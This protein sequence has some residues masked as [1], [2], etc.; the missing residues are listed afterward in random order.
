MIFLSFKNQPLFYHE[1]PFILLF[2]LSTFTTFSQTQ[3]IDS[4]PKDITVLNKGWKFHACD[5]VEWAKP[6]FDDRHWRA[7]N[8]TLDVSKFPQMR[9][10][11]IGW[12]RI[13][14]HIDNSLLNKPLAYRIFQSIASKVFINGKLTDNHY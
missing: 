4:I 8:P 1:K 14:S 3:T 13:Q 11:P 7:I 10:Q 12:L 9:R 2:L 6:D 5:N